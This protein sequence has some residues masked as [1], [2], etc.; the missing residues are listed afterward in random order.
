MYESYI[1]TQ[2]ENNNEETLKIEKFFHNELI[3]PGL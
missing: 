2:N 1:T 3:N